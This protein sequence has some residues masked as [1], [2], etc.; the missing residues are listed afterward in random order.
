[1]TAL[2]GAGAYW[3]PKI[4]DP[5][6]YVPTEAALAAARAELDRIQAFHETQCELCRRCALCGQL[7]HRLDDFGLCTK[8]STPHLEWRQRV[9]KMEA[10][11][12]GPR[13]KKSRAR[14]AAAR[15]A[16]TT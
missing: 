5:S 7:T 15:R 3:V 2:V 8:I 6:E 11:A 16:V 4:E 10:A 1:M 14:T 13:F 9:N 12:A